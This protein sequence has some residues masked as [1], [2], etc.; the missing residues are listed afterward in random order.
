MVIAALCSFAAI[1]LILALVFFLN[2]DVLKSVEK[3]NSVP[4]SKSETSLSHIEE[5]RENEGLKVDDLSFFKH[6]NDST[7]ASSDTKTSEKEDENPEA[8]D[9][10]HTYITYADGTGEWVSITPYLTKNTYDFLNLAI[11]NGKM[12]YYVDNKCVSFLGADISEDQTYVDFN[13]L[14]KAGVDFVMLKVGARGYA[15]GKI[16][17]DGYL[18][19]NLK[20]ATDAGL[21]I[22]LYFESNA[23]TEKEAKAEAEAVSDAVG[24]YT[25]D[26]PVAFM[27]K[28]QPEEASR[29]DK[30]SRNER[31]KI[32]KAFC[33]AIKNKGFTPM[34]YGDKAWLIKYYDP[35]KLSDYD[36]W[37]SQTDTDIPDYPYCF[38]IWQYNLKGSLEGIAG[39][40]HLNISFTDYASR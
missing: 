39:D 33:T 22:G 34:I 8:T 27:M 20:R 14:K 1:I 12:K 32:A 25:I 38:S 40:A 29:I 5:S 15:D 30:L 16:S 13:K 9:G 23:V 36:V 10:K 2:Y 17:I 37:L 26:Y 35:S 18:T 31:T 7:E 28:Y 3:Q 4:E 24:E 21:S 6:E 19:D 11:S